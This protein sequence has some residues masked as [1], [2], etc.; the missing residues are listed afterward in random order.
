MGAILRGPRASKSKP[1]TQ[2]LASFVKTTPRRVDGSTESRFH[3][4]G[5]GGFGPTSHG[6]YTRASFRRPIL[7]VGNSAKATDIKSFFTDP[8]FH[9]LFYSS[10]G[11]P[12]HG[13]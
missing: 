11:A 2:I 4:D 9:M 1:R 12:A 10:F 7:E 3:V 8:P 6:V 13:V 5:R